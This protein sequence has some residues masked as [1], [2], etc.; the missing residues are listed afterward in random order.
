MT[1]QKAILKSLISYSLFFF[2]LIFFTACSSNSKSNISN[3]FEIFDSF[4]NSLFVKNKLNQNYPLEFV[5]DNVDNKKSYSY[6]LKFK[7]TNEDQY[8][9]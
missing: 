4:L 7:Q 2:G 1:I 9:N 3:E 6:T 5:I 8:K